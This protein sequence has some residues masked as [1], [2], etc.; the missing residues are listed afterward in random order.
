MQHEVGSIVDG[1]VTGITKFGAFVEL[2][3]G[4]VGMVHISEVSQTYV[5]DISE[6]LKDQQQVKVKILSIGEDGKV[7]LSIKKALPP[8]PFVKRE[9]KPNN[10]N[11]KVGGA[12]PRP[13]NNNFSRPAGNTS[14]G[15]RP[16]NFN[17]SAQAA[18]GPATFEDMLSK[19]MTTSEDKF[20][21]VKKPSSNRRGGY[22]KKGPKDYD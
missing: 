22:G 21:E 10:F 12:A 4:T 2:E 13:M 20:T 14:G 19:F 3:G 9:N 15:G 17:R 11:N 16:Q 8:A 6:H 7:S 1:K 5:N 18:K